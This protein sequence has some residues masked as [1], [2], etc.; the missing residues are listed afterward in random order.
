VKEKPWYSSPANK[1]TACNGR[2]VGASSRNGV[3][4][5]RLAQLPRMGAAYPNGTAIAGD[6]AMTAKAT[7]AEVK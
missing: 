1:V 3:I 4:F 7:T 2:L 6:M 5:S